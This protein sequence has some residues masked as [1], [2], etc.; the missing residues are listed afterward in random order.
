MQDNVE[1][2]E[3][4]IERKELECMNEEKWAKQDGREGWMNKH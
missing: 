3:S 1:G 2:G 4:C